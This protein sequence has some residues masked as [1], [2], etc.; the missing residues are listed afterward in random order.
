MTQLSRIYSI[1][2]YQETD[3]A[4]KFASTEQETACWDIFS[5]QTPVL[6]LGP[7]TQMWQTTKNDC[8]ETCNFKDSN[9]KQSLHM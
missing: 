1:T 6:L 3:S 2:E 4:S 8:R 9:Q 5:Q 7:C